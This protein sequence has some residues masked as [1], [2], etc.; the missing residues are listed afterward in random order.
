MLLVV[1]LLFYGWGEPVYIVIMFLSIIIDY[2]HGLLVEKFRSD[3][4]KARWFVAQSVIFNLALLFFFNGGLG[5]LYDF[6]LAFTDHFARV[7]EIFTGY[8]KTP[9][10]Q[11]DFNLR[12]SNVIAD[13]MIPQRALMG[14]WAM[15]IPALYL[16][17]MYLKKTAVPD[18]YIPLILGCIGVVGCMVWTVATMTV[19]DWQSVLAGLCSAAVQG[20]LVAGASVY[21][22]QVVK[23]AGKEE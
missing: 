7:K 1:S 17:G 21:V 9:A 16:V 5:F 22:N 10:N 3:D 11:P 12:F 14:G 15:G 13:L 23:Q 8:Y 4:K 2:T 6:D 18:K 20:V 19:F